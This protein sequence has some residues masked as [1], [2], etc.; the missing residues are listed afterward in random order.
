V[1]TGARTFYR[2]LT[3]KH[4]DEAIANAC[5]WSDTNEEELSRLKYAL[6]AGPEQSKAHRQHASAART[7]SNRWKQLSAALSDQRRGELHAAADEV[8]K[9]REAHAATIALVQG[10]D[11]LG[12]V[13]GAAWRAM[14]EAA[15]TYATSID[16][17]NDFPSHGP[18]GEEHSDPLCPLCQQSTTA[19]SH[20]LH[21]FAG[22]VSAQS[23]KSLR[24]AESDLAAMRLALSQE[25]V[26][27]S[28]AEKVL[29]ENVG[30]HDPEIVKRVAAAWALASEVK[31]NWTEFD[32]NALCAGVGQNSL[33]ADLDAIASRWEAMANAIDD[34][35]DDAARAQFMTQCR[36]LE[37]RRTLGKFAAEI[38]AR[39]DL[40]RKKAAYDLAKTGC[41][42]N[43]VTRKA[44]EW[45]D[46]YLTERAK[47]L[48]EREVERFSLG[49]LKVELTRSSTSVATG[50]KNNLT[51]ARRQTR[52]SEVLSE[53]E[54]RALS[55]A[56]FFTESALERPG[57]ILVVDDPISSLD[58]RRSAAVAE[59]LVE[60]CETRQVIVFTHDLLFLEELGEA[61]KRRAVEPAIVRVFSTTS[62]A[63]NVDPSGVPWKGQ[64]VEKRVNTL[65]NGMA[66]LRRSR[67]TSLTDYEIDARN[68]YTKLREA[69]ERFVEEVLFG[70][71]IQRYRQSVETKKLRLVSVSHDVARRFDDAFSKAS[72]YSHDNSQVENVAV[73]EPEEIEQDLRD[74][75]S[76]I[77]DVKQEQKA[78]E[79]ARR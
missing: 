18:I 62:V 40:L 61:G 69:Y 58:R 31:A 52:V 53:G 21:R 60:E 63:G 20:R 51:G 39:R 37:D 26:I 67:E 42:R 50:Y 6:T 44:N 57:G 5:E 68:T 32:I 28:P 79:S 56:A 7:L 73:P 55:L 12:E 34:V 23:S 47:T 38:V 43:E 9:C 13:G 16:N 27:L 45:V 36:E 8:T 3:A 35:Q 19:V 75:Q 10:R 74:L 64:N 65:L 25:Q 15:A 41:R 48:F 29:I 54:Q 33:S 22:F 24:K 78:T 72:K 49:H 14:W 1:D 46:T 76:L 71:V 59:K 66:S 11:P 17:F 77:S 2:D 70:G 30:A 4:S